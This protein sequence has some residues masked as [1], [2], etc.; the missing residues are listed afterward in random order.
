M[1]AGIITRRGSAWV[2]VHYS[3][4]NKRFCI[5]VIP[6]VTFWFILRGGKAPREHRIK[7]AQMLERKITEKGQME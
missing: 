2:G 7:F 1:K 6:C 3:S 4:Y 5:N